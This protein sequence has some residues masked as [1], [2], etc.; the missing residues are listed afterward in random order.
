[1]IAAA[2]VEIHASTADAYPTSIIFAPT[3]DAKGGGDV[4]TLFYSS[5][6][7]KQLGGVSGVAPGASWFGADFG[8]MPKI[9]LGS[10]GVSFGGLEVG[11]DAILFGDSDV[12]LKPV[13]NAKLQLL[14]E[15]K[16]SPHVA[17]G[18]M[19]FDPFKLSRSMNMIY[20]ALTKT[21]EINGTSFGRVTLG[22]SGMANK[23]FNTT[24]KTKNAFYATGP[25]KESAQLAIL[26]GYES[27]AFGPVS[28]ALDY[29]GGVSEVSSANAVFS[30]TPIDGATWSVGASFG[31]DYERNNFFVAG[32]TYLYV[33]WNV[34]KVFGPKEAPPPTPP[35]AAPPAANPAAPPSSAAPASP[36]A[37]GAPASP[38][39]APP[40]AAAPAVPAAPPPAAAQPPAAPPKP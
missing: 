23:F 40:P 24:D 18:L 14:T 25:F 2:C 7:L 11:F 6:Y 27:P 12:P 30:L 10:S 4:G 35:A 26:G 17:F 15:T 5:I 20:G 39:A 33:S 28:F 21:I 3:G 19:E 38:A 31:N 16:Y 36:A 32:I 37:P 1:M 22:F 8:V 34:L 13:F 29:I 9:P